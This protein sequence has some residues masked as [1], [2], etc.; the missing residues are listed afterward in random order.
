MFRICKLIVINLITH[1]I[2]CLYMLKVLISVLVSAILPCP[3][4]WIDTQIYSITQ[5]Y[6][7]PD[8]STIP[9]SHNYTTNKGDY[10]KGENWEVAEPSYS[11][12]TL[13]TAKLQF[14]SFQSFETSCLASS[15]W[16]SAFLCVNVLNLSPARVPLLNWS[17]LFSWDD[18]VLGVNRN[19]RDL[20][21]HN[22]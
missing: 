13:N 18:V 21:V 19:L 9:T 11:Q 3:R 15:K 4:Y 2:S 14:I 7:S 12:C 22:R 17:T 10:Q 20:K 6:Q 16:L 8:I 1:Y 5:R